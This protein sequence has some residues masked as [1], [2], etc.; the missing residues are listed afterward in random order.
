MRAFVYNTLLAALLVVLGGFYALTAAISQTLSNQEQPCLVGGFPYRLQWSPDGYTLAFFTSEGGF[1]L[2]TAEAN[3]AP[4]PINP[5][6]DFP[7]FKF[8]A[9]GRYALDGERVYDLQTGEVLYEFVDVGDHTFT[10]NG[11]YVKTSDGDVI[12][13]MAGDALIEADQVD[14]SPDGRFLIVL[15]IDTTVVP[16]LLTYSLVDVE[17]MD[18]GRREMPLRSGYKRFFSTEAYDYLVTYTTTG[19][20]D[21]WD[22][23]TGERL[24]LSEATYED[25][26]TPQLSADGRYLA[27]GGSNGAGYTITVWDTETGEQIA[28]REGAAL[29]EFSPEGTQLL[30]GNTVSRS[31]TYGPIWYEEGH[32]VWSFLDG[33]EIVLDDVLPAGQT[34]REAVWGPGDQLAV[35]TQE[36]AYIWSL[37]GLLAGDA[38]QQTLSIEN[39]AFLSVRFTRDGTRLI[40]THDDVMTATPVRATTRTYLYDIASGDVLLSSTLTQPGTLMFSPDQTLTAYRQYA[41]GGGGL[42]ELAL[43]DALTGESLGQVVFDRDVVI[44]PDWSQV[45]YWTRTGEGDTQEWHLMVYEVS[46]GNERELLHLATC[47]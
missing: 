28:S 30:L 47:Q 7:G 6:E 17:Q 12:D 11:R 1:V 42:E 15:D 27:M 33:T 31:D 21:L 45:A 25:G 24:L 19:A 3:P 34:S 29:F 5:P 14:M 22:L 13:I 23:R 32:V 46:T 38:P 9:T 20:F 39:S 2:D 16:S 36:R 4:R 26:L 40:T 41:A 43:F 10:A 37:D 44:N 35:M 18:A 8:D